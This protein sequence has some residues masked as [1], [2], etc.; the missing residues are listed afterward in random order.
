MLS[1]EGCG[2]YEKEEG[3]CYSTV[4]TSCCSEKVKMNALRQYMSLTDV[5]ERERKERLT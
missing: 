1:R 2:N 3:R 5:K 4:Q